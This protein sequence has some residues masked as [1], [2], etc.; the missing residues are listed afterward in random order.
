MIEQ[1]GVTLVLVGADGDRRRILAPARAARGSRHFVEGLLFR[2]RHL[3]ERHLAGV[4]A[5]LPFAENGAI[6]DEAI[7]REPVEAYSLTHS[8]L[9]K[10]NDSG[11]YPA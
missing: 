2:R 9:F 1:S 7:A 3:A 10:R 11:D 5:G 6:V 8:A 4:A